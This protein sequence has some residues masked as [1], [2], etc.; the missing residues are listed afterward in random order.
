MEMASELQTARL[1]VVIDHDCL[2][3]TLMLENL[4]GHSVRQLICVPVL[5]L[6]DNGQPSFLHM[7]E[8][9]N[10]FS[11]VQPFQWIYVADTLWQ[12]VFANS[13]QRDG[14]YLV[15]IQEPDFLQVTAGLLVDVGQYRSCIVEL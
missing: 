13:V 2:I 4:N 12:F 8:A 11:C 15:S 1:Y 7:D 14:H 6:D 3:H 9:L 10:L 5:A